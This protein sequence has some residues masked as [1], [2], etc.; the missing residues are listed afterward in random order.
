MSNSRDEAR[1]KHWKAL[2]IDRP[3]DPAPKTVDKQMHLEVYCESSYDMLEEWIKRG[4]LQDQQKCYHLYELTM[5]GRSQTGLVACASIDDYLNGVIKS[6]KHKGRKEQD[7]IRHVDTLQC[8]K[9][10]LIFL[11]Y[12]KDQTTRRGDTAKIKQQ[13]PMFAFIPKMGASDIK[14]GAWMQ[15]RILQQLQI[16]LRK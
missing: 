5:D 16:H 7:R 13:K 4:P 12:R 11:A 10:G 1:E 15:K 14:A 2:A 8:N 9:T 3:G 6:M